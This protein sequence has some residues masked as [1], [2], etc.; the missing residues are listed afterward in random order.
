MAKIRLH[1]TF[2]EE[3]IRVPILYALSHRHAVVPN[4]LRANV[5][6]R[7]GWVIVELEGEAD[8]L[9]AGVAYLRDEG[10]GVDVIEF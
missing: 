10:V 1:L 3:L 7:V 5:E 9:D 8:E 2:P 4:I 6:E